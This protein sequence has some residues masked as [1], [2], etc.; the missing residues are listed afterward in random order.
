MKLQ[1][2][3]EILFFTYQIGK[4]IKTVV[5][6]SIAC[7]YFKHICS[8]GSSNKLPK[9]SDLKQQKCIFSQ[10][11]RPEIPKS[12]YQVETSVWTGVQFFAYSSL[13]AHHTSWLEVPITHTSASV[14]ILPT[15]LLSVYNALPPL[16][17]IRSIVMASKVH[18]DNPG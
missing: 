1:N 8:C 16:F 6:S 14:V 18:L 17:L 3:N 9:L 5:Y 11:R 13:M 10:F 15:P 7:E 12:V 4:Q 2:Y